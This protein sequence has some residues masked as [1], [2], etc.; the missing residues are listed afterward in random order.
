[1]SSTV[2][3]IFV[4]AC[5]FG[6]ALFGIFLRSRL[7]ADH[8]DGDSK[9][10]VKLVMGLIATLTALVL[11]LLISSA[12]SAYDA[13]EAEVEQ[14]GVNI[15]QLDRA[16]GRFGPQGEEARSVLRSLVT[17]DIARTWPQHGA[18][19]LAYATGQLIAEG[20]HLVEEIAALPTSTG[21]EQLAQSRALTLLS[22]IAETRRLMTVQSHGS[23]SWFVLSVLV[24][25]LALLFF[26]FG[27]FARLNTTVVVALVAGAM[28]VATAYVLILEMN[29][30]YRGWMQISGAPVRDALQQIQPK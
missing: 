18:D 12:H 4:F 25:W 2:T 1:M 26:G 24:S 3:G 8:L 20:D 9:D 15:F 7:P 13:Q 11:G 16:L 23:L 14:M 22:R 17:H 5:A 27:L 19:R 6:A 29:Q 10:V 30:P 28:S 21:G